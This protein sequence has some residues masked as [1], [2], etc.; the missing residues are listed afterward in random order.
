MSG[1]GNDDSAGGD[2]GN[3]GVRKQERAQQLKPEVMSNHRM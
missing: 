1:G 3:D 2:D